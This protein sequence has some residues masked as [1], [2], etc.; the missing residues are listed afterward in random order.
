VEEGKAFLASLDELGMGVQGAAW[1][2]FRDLDDWRY[3]VATPLT[4][5]MGRKRVYSLLADAL[6]VIGTPEGLSVFDVHLAS[7]QDPIFQ[8]IS[9][10]VNWQG[11][12]VA[13][14][15]NC[16]LNGVQVNGVMYR[17]TRHARPI[18]ARLAKRTEVVFKRKVKEV[19]AH[20]A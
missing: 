15:E 4:D 8:L 13:F 3:Y 18:D 17:L 16:S 12:G 14:F 1:L 9:G 7:P 2:Y 5:T 19:L 6:D 11:G 10:A 20:A